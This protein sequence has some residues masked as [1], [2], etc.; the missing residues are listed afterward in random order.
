MRLTVFVHFLVALCFPFSKTGLGAEI[1]L[2]PSPKASPP[3]RLPG[4]SD[5]ELKQNLDRKR[6]L[7]EMR[8]KKD[9]P[10]AKSQEEKRNDSLLDETY[11]PRNMQLFVS[12]TLVQPHPFT[13]GDNKDYLSD[14]SAHNHVFW[15]HAQ[16]K[17]TDKWQLW[18]GARIAGFSGTGFFKNLPGRF[19]FTYFG[20]F[21]GVGKLDPL[22][23]KGGIS[24]AGKAAD[25]AAKENQN[26]EFAVR[27]GYLFAFGLN[28][29]TGGFRFDE[30]SEVPFSQ[31]KTQKVGYEF[32]GLSAEF[33]YTR[34]YFGAVSVNILAGGQYGQQKSFL[35]GGVG[36]GG[37]I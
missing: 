1:L 27:S 15:R 18:Y 2:P 26:M 24:A 16:E 31:T 21:I 22:P 33:M 32:P 35:W 9:E 4:E 10:P 3:P 29:F 7:R 23:T 8:E 34:I 30:I 6:R 14:L 11:K 5:E 20:P 13:S 28:G 37:W 36:V 17:P 19:G 12:A 25:L